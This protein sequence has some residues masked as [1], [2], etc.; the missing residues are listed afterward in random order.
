MEFEVEPTTRVP[1]AKE[2]TLVPYEAEDSWEV[3]GVEE[4][5]EWDTVLQ[6]SSFSY[7]AEEGVLRET[8]ATHT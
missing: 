6:T 2:V 8:M 1:P 4:E 3:E 5:V 7:T